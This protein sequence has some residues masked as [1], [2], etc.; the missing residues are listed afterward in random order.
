MANSFHYV[1]N[2]KE[3]LQK[4]SGYVKEEHSFL[5]VEYDTDK[6][7]STWVPYPA[8]FESLKKLFNEAG[9]SS[10]IKMNEHPSVYRSGIMYS[11]I[12]KR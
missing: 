5:I 9:Y 4:L 3:L 2:K 11:A 1:K 10:V 8:R 6:P 7:V 12:I